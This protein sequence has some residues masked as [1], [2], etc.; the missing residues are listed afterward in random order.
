[1]QTME[2]KKWVQGWVDESV[3]CKKYYNFGRSI[4]LLS[5]NGY[6]FSF[7]KPFGLTS[8]TFVRGMVGLNLV[9]KSFNCFN[10][11]SIEKIILIVKKIHWLTSSHFHIYRKGKSPFLTIQL[12]PRFGFGHRTPKPGIFSHPTIK[13]V[14]F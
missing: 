2:S 12:W 14:Q 9:R 10:F 7:V 11:Y 4:F 8:G 6:P 13:T 5:K 1:M 3:W